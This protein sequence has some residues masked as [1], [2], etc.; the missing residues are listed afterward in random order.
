MV[1]EIAAHRDRAQEFLEEPQGRIGNAERTARYGHTGGVLELTGPSSLLDGVERSLFSEGALLA[2][3]DA[4]DS[5]RIQDAGRREAF[6]ELNVRA[7]ILLLMTTPTTGDSFTAAAGQDS[8][9]ASACELRSAISAAREVLK[10]A[11]ILVTP[12]GVR[13]Q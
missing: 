8:I 5:L 12:G 11:G 2:R 3:L 7:G 9:T 6:V 13:T 4:N 10:K 1:T